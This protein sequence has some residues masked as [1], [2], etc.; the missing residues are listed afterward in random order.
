[1]NMKRAICILLVF[2]LFLIV[3]LSADACGEENSNERICAVPQLDDSLLAEIGRQLAF[4]LK[5]SDNDVDIRNEQVFLGK[6][7]CSYELVN[8]AV[9]KTNISYIP[10]FVEKE[11]LCFAILSESSDGSTIQL[12][13]GF[14]DK[15]GS[16]NEI[17][18]IALL[19]DRKNCYLISD[20]GVQLIYESENVV[21][22]R[23]ALGSGTCLNL[24][25]MVLT[26]LYP[27]FAFDSELITASRSAITLQVPIVPQYNTN[28]CWAAST[29]SI[30]NYL[31]THNYT[32]YD[33]AVSVFGSQNWDQTAD[34]ITSF[35]ALYN[36][37]GISYVYYANFTAPSDST[38]YNNIINGY[39]MYGRWLIADGAGNSY[40]YHRTVIS[41]IDIGSY[42]Y[43]MDPNFGY[44]IAQFSGGYY[45]YV[46]YGTIATLY[47]T[48]YGSMI[49]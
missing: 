39:P 19:Y 32:A 22:Y 7:I 38:I 16:P 4:W 2:A 37:Y 18:A 20:N 12:T 1:M 45:N 35:Q 30:G 9:V 25:N 14:V 46:W 43:V 29:A 36:N 8:G 33:I 27:L 24:S 48:G 40:G 3:P 42:I 13:G 23:S 11:L 47:L 28:L 44:T 49:L 6:P 17:G 26:E 21:Q 41:G 10:I 15:L 31:T 34:F 5:C